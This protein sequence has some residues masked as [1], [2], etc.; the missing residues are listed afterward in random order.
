MNKVTAPEK[1]LARLL[2][3]LERELLE[4]CD[5]EVLGAARD[6]GMNPSMKGSAAFVGLK[7]FS[8][9]R[10]SDFFELDLCKHLPGHMG[11]NAAVDRLCD[12]GDIPHAKPAGDPSDER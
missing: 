4:A 1:A 2:A 7:Y 11:D 9:P 6:L 5:E 8:Q 3:A 12:D 10:M